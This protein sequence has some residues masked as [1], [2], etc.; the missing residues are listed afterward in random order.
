MSIPEQPPILPRMDWV[1]AHKEKG[2]EYLVTSATPGAG[3]LRGE[4]L[5]HY[6]RMEP[7]GN[8]PVF[9]RLL[10]EWEEKMEPANP[11]A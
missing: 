6:R 2:G 10:S 1:W 7:G 9:S 5:V 11:S 3:K 4:I 8:G